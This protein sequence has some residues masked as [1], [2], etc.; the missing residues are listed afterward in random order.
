MDV[1]QMCT[2]TKL[3]FFFFFYNRKKLF[4]CYVIF[5][6]FLV[7]FDLDEL[8]NPSTIPWA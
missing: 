2:K 4:K 3:V 8:K 7:I 6:I 5:F 1:S